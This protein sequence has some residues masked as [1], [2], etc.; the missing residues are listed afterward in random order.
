MYGA[1]RRDV[2]AYQAIDLDAVA[3]DA[4]SSLDLRRYI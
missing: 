4:K 1:P 3:Q 2:R